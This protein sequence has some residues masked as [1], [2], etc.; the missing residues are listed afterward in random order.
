MRDRLTVLLMLA[1]AAAGCSGEPADSASGVAATPVAAAPATSRPTACNLLT[2]SEI[3]AIIGADVLAP[4]PNGFECAF[5]RK[6][7]NGLMIR[8][9]RVRL[10]EGARTATPYDLYEQYTTAIGAALGSEY[11]LQPVAGLGTVAGWDGDAVLTAE[12]TGDRNFLLVVQ[13][14]GTRPD[15]ELDQAESLAQTALARLRELAP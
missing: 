11:Q 14:D 10:E 2:P 12:R 5:R 1:L 7:A 9:V 13:L 3:G 4:E 6:D 8:A 15:V